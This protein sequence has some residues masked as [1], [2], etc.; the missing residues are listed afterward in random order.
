[1]PA[2]PETPPRCPDC[3]ATPTDRAP[4]LLAASGD[5]WLCVT[6]KAA[7]D[8]DPSSR[9]HPWF[10]VTYVPSWAIPLR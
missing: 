2:P 7:R 5:R 1:M 3:N 9:D 6:C 10:G 8:G 4:L